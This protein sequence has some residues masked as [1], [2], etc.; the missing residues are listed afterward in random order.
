MRRGRNACSPGGA[1]C[2]SSAECAS[3]GDNCVAA[4]AAAA[5][6][7]A[8]TAAAAPHDGDCRE[9]REPEASLGRTGGA[10]EVPERVAAV[11]SHSLL[12]RKADAERPD[13]VGAGMVAGMATMIAA[14]DDD[15]ESDAE[16]ASDQLCSNSDSDEDRERWL[17]DEQID[18]GE[19]CVQQARQA[20]LDKWDVFDTCEIIDEQVAREVGRRR[21]ATRCVNA[22]RPRRMAIKACWQGVSKLGA[23]SA[24]I[25][26]CQFVDDHS[27][28][29]RF[30]RSLRRRL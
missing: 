14:E 11:P 19:V 12:K 22:L 3:R 9:P 4:A 15:A 13:E 8:A 29:D 27:E 21:L 16:A 20:E 24:R 2:A 30:I 10:G 25:V 7:A 28:S 17:Y 1:E 5:A 6:T 26:H 18:A 23:E